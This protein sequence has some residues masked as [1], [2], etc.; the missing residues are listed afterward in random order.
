LTKA[1]MAPCNAAAVRISRQPAARRSPWASSFPAA[2]FQTCLKIA[3]ARIPPS[4][5]I[6]MF[7][8]LYRSG[9]LGPSL[10]RPRGTAPSD[11]EELLAEGRTRYHCRNKLHRRPP[12]RQEFCLHNR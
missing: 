5:L 7:A 12:P 9:L 2:I 1:K 8:G 4:T 11:L 10:L 3:P 6:T